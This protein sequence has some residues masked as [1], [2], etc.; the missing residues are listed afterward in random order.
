MDVAVR[1][2][3]AAKPRPLG[4]RRG[5]RRLGC[6]ALAADR[7]PSRRS[8]A[9]HR[10]S[11]DPSVD[12]GAL[13]AREGRLDQ[14]AD[15]PLPGA[16]RLRV[17]H[18]AGH[19]RLRAPG[20]AE[21]ALRRHLRPSALH[22]PRPRHRLRALGGT[23]LVRCV[24]EG[25]RR[26]SQTTGDHRSAERQEDDVRGPAED[27]D[28]DVHARGPLRAQW[29][30][31]RHPPDRSAPRTTRELGRRHGDRHRAEACELSATR[32]QRP[33]RPEGHCPRRSATEGRRQPRHACELLRLR[34]TGRAPPRERRR[35]V[36]RQTVRL[37]GVPGLRF[38][39]DRADHA[40][41]LNARKPVSG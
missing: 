35:S 37:P 1:R 23:Y 17:R 36:A 12:D 25:R 33:R 34:P 16:S 40:E 6:R 21:T 10:S 24:P 31:N 11:R 9:E 27:A 28:A 41:A 3:L 14:D 13:G 2:P 18:L 32:C 20:G 19:T 8:G 5:L 39:D 4:H 29:E 7:K 38:S 22:V 26:R 15:V 30:R